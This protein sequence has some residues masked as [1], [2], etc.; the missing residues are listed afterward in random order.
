M[1]LIPE[2]T[3]PVSLEVRRKRK[4]PN[5]SSIVQS[6]QYHQNANAENRTKRGKTRAVRERSMVERM[7]YKI[8]ERR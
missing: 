8:T 1:L 4:P 6:M 7:H 3:P 2:I 5:A